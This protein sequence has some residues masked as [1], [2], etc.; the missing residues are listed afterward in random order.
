MSGRKWWNGLHFPIE[1]LSAPPDAVTFESSLNF[2][3]SKT[4]GPL[5]EM[6][7]GRQEGT[8]SGPWAALAT[9]HLCSSGRL[10][11]QLQLHATPRTQLLLDGALV[12][13]TRP[14]STVQMYPLGPPTAALYVHWVQRGCSEVQVRFF[15]P[16][17]CGENHVE[18]LLFDSQPGRPL[19]EVKLAYA[20]GSLMLCGD[21]DCTDNRRFNIDGAVSALVLQLE[22][23]SGGLMQRIT[24]TMQDGSVHSPEDWVSPRSRYF[25]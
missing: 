8:P 9:G 24:Y 10:L 23:D 6:V 19:E 21:R 7:A 20:R 5:A 12:A 22:W 16:P 15:E 11:Q 18:A 3:R 25:S 14:E 17:K 2:N 4:S 13:T 1:I